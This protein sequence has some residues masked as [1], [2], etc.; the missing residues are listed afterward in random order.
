VDGVVK[1]R[2]RDPLGCV[3]ELAS[4]AHGCRALVQD[5]RLAIGAVAARGYLLPDQLELVVS[6]HGI[7]PDAATIATNVTAYTLHTLNLACTPGVAPEELEARLDPAGR[8]E[9]L[10]DLARDQVIPA[11]RRQC[12]ARLV[13]L[14]KQTMDHY[15]AES[16]RLHKEDDEPELIE[17]FDRASILDE[18]AARKAKASH[19]E[20]RTTFHRAYKEL[21]LTLKRD[22]EDETDREESSAAAPQTLSPWERVPEGRVRASAP[23]GA[24]ASAAAEA[25]VRASAPTSADASTAA[26]ARVRADAP[27]DAPAAPSP[28]E[29]MPGC[30]NE[31]GI[32]RDAPPQVE[33][34]KEDSAT[35]PGSEQEGPSAVPSVVPMSPDNGRDRSDGIGAEPKFRARVAPHGSLPPPP[36]LGAGVITP[37][38]SGPEVSQPG[39]EETFGHPHGGVGRP[40]PSNGSH[41]GPPRAA[42][43]GVAEALTRPSAWVAGAESRARWCDAIDGL[44]SGASR[45]Q[46]QPPAEQPHVRVDTPVDGEGPSHDA[47][48][49]PD[50]AAAGCRGHLQASQGDDP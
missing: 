17:L 26:E 44:G 4:F 32:G 25:R 10:R 42:A 12:A 29:E 47:S 19:A 45:T 27:P 18:P 16:D 50:A 46:P 33:G 6:D 49:R 38:S 43:L 35:E 23:P 40:A 31:P 36:P 14:L 3:A 37:P 15:Q 22:A 5:L 9:A 41:C 28:A 48:R 34:E 2:A 30:A 11:D 39:G 21:C 8:P 24:D 7:A 1:R 20:A 13:E